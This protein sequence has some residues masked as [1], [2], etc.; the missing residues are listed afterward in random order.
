M[1]KTINYIFVLALAILA[2]SCGEKEP[3]GGLLRGVF[4]ADVP[5]DKAVVTLPP[6]S[7]KSYSVK[8]F[9]CSS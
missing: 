2:C 7:S 3:V 5:G 4:Y 9:G 1:K 8:V 6:G